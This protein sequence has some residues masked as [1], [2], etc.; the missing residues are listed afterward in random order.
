MKYYRFDET[1]NRL[2]VWQAQY[3]AISD[4]GE[5][6]WFY[7]PTYPLDTVDNLEEYFCE[8]CQMD[9]YFVQPGPYAWQREQGYLGEDCG[10]QV[11]AEEVD[12]D[13]GLPPDPNKVVEVTVPG[14]INGEDQS[15]KLKVR[16]K[17]RRRK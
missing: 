11:T 4:N 8:E 7:G 13:V 6:E 16:A 3:Y 17:W 5:L 1:H 15:I 14:K 12:N 10:V 9:H 2:E